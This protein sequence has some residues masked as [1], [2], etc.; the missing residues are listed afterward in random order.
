[1]PFHAIY[2][3][4]LFAA[5]RVIMLCVKASILVYQVHA[6]TPDTV[7]ESDSVVTWNA[8][9]LPEMVAFEA[10]NVGVLSIPRIGLDVNVYQTEDQ[11]EA[12]DHGVA[13]FKSTSA[14]DG[15]IGLSAHNRTASG[16][17]EFFR[18]LHLL[19]VGDTLIYQT[20]LGMREYRVTT[21]HNISDEDWSYLF[22]TADNR[23]TLITCIDNHPDRR[24]MV[25]A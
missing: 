12:M 19:V 4:L 11:M 6:P 21:I 3:P 16:Q 8:F 15:N 24:L 25:Q 5:N 7:W 20:A 2:I 9:T 18:D 1:M 22:R 17:G 14:W 23:L 13:H 10:G